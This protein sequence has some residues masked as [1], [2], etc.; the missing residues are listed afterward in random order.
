MCSNNKA[1]KATAASSN[2]YLDDKH[3]CEDISLNEL[4]DKAGVSYSTYLL[5]LKICSKGNSVENKFQRNVMVSKSET[6]SGVLNLPPSTI[7]KLVLKRL[8][9]DS[10]H[11]LSS[12]LAAR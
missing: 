3:A 8:P 7:V 9:T 11:C 6:N 12:S 5:G 10:C 2:R 4:L 1:G